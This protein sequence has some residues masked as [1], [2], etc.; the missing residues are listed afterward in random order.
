MDKET[1]KAIAIILAD[2]AAIGFI[3]PVCLTWLKSLKEAGASILAI[4]GV[5]SLTMVAIVLLVGILCHEI[6]ELI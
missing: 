2:A 4:G 1:K 3:L 5:S 6:M